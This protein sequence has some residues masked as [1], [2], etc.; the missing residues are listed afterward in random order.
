MDPN[1]ESLASFG[2]SSQVLFLTSFRLPL[3]LFTS[4]FLSF[5]SLVSLSLFSPPCQLTH[6]LFQSLTQT[7]KKYLASEITSLRT[8]TQV[9]HLTSFSPSL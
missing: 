1:L 9:R 2:P 6:T 5:F 7:E 8:L 4:L 3:L